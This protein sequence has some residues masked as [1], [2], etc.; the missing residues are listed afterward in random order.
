[1]LKLALEGDGLFV[2]AKPGAAEGVLCSV[3]SFAFITP[4]LQ[5]FV[6]AAVVAKFTFAADLRTEGGPETF[7]L[8]FADG[9]TAARES[10]QEQT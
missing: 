4:D 9:W 3:Q 7:G 10:S 1:M 6:Q 5:S 2:L 8:R